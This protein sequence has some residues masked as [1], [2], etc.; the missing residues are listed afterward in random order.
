MP[1]KFPYCSA[2]SYTEAP[3]YSAVI[4]ISIILFIHDTG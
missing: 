1:P 3:F 2:N 4:V